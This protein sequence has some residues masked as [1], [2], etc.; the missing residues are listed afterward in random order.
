MSVAGRMSSGRCRLKHQAVALCILALVTS[1]F[2]LA[3]VGPDDSPGRA[4]EAYQHGD[5]ACAARLFEEAIQQF[6]A[7]GELYKYLG[8]AYAGCAFEKEPTAR[9][10]HQKTWDAADS[11]AAKKSLSALLTYFDKGGQDPRLVLYLD[12]LFD[13]PIL[14]GEA[15]EV[16]R[17]RTHESPDK[18]AFWRWL[19]KLDDAT[20]HV[21]EGFDAAQKWYHLE[22]DSSEAFVLLGHL[23]LRECLASGNGIDTIRHVVDDNIL[24]V[25]RYL[26]AHPTDSSA[27]RLLLEFHQVRGWYLVAKA[28]REENRATV[29]RLAREADQCP[30]NPAR[31]AVLSACELG[32]KYT[33]LLPVAPPSYLLGPC[34]EREPIA[35]MGSSWIRPPKLLRQT[36]IEYPA[37]ERMKGSAGR[38]V[39]ENVI[40]QDGSVSRCR[41]L[42]GASPQ[43][44]FAAL[45]AARHMKYERPYVKSPDDGHHFV[46]VYWLLTLN[47]KPTR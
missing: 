18:A 22:P 37:I 13:S 34:A 2:W 41:I 40:A 24:S 17:K 15:F 42:K 28:E 30:T 36:F 32:N 19:A 25:T 12:A 46:S 4:L 5:Y 1:P 47:F 23:F 43:Y 20:G 3:A 7:Y 21:A 14:E 35:P 26:Q 16:I 33:E 8:Y 9:E 45:E 31:D 10:P 44:D 6:P 29:E 27:V 11:A 39:V 38:V